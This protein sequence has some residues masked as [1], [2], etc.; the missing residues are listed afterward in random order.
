MLQKLIRT[1]LSLLGS[2]HSLFSPIFTHDTDTF[3]TI[4]LSY[5]Q[6]HFP[7]PFSSFVH[8]RGLVITQ[9]N[10]LIYQMNH[11]LIEHVKV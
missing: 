10:V 6:T 1:E 4:F 8:I 7:N 2:R 3:F 11:N 5:Q 9:G